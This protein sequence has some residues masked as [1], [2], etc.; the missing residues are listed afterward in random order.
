MTILTRLARTAVTLALSATV[1][2]MTLAPSA[3]ADVTSD[4]D[5]WENERLGE[6]ADPPTDTTLTASAGTTSDLDDAG[7]PWENE[8]LAGTLMEST[9]WLTL[10]IR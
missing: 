5:P 10:A 2:S 4:G 6:P 3:Q 1:F 9:A 7:D 8:R